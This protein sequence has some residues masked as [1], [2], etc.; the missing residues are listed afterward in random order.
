M[1][2]TL[3]GFYSVNNKTELTTSE[4][5]K[6]R[7]LVYDYCGINLHEGK[8]A[9]VK[10]RLMKRLRSL[11]L[12]SFTDYL[13]YLE[14]DI[15][16][17]EFVHLIDILTTNKTSFFRESSHF[18]YIVQEII[19]A[20]GN[21]QVKWWSAG[22]STGE[23]P[24]T[25]AMTLKEGLKTVKN[26]PVKILGT[27]LSTEVIQFA[28]QGEYPLEKLKGIP[29]YFIKKYFEAMTEKKQYYRVN[30]SMKNMIT[31]GCLNLLDPWPM[32]GPFQIIMCRNVMI[33]FDKQTQQKLV[34]RFYSLLEPGGYLFIGHS[35]SVTNKEIGL[36]TIQP[37]A[38]QKT[39]A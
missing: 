6:I 8:Q 34:E 2:T 20:I 16:K 35:E 36:R 10:G 4:F 1:S 33:Y 15:T 30:D 3:N 22:C 14:R 32:K 17:Q 28:K 19:P 27:D 9:L 13:N 26:P 7:N 25:M 18:D 23:E 37:A 31:Y 39:G 24:I 21:R 5:Q 29:D 12:N 11:H 38:Y